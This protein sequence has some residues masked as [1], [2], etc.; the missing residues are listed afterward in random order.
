MNKSIG[1][2]SIVVVADGQTSCKLDGEVA[3]LHIQN[4]MY[5]S[6]DALG[7]DIWERIQTPKKVSKIRDAIIAEYAV[8]QDRCEQDLFSFLQKMARLGLIDIKV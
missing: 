7:A 2:D 8:D 1:H 4:G 5:Y 6:L 3:I